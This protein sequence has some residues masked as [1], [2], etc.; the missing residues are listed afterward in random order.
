V[1]MLGDVEGNNQGL[2]DDSEKDDDSGVDDSDEIGEEAVHQWQAT[3]E[4]SL[5]EI[6][7]EALYTARR[8]GFTRRRSFSFNGFDTEVGY[9]R[10][11]VA[12]MVDLGDGEQ[13]VEGQDEVIELEEDKKN[14]ASGGESVKKDELVKAQMVVDAEVEVEVEDVEDKLDKVEAEAGTNKRRRRRVKQ[15][16]GSGSPRRSLRKTDKK[17]GNSANDKVGIVKE[18]GIAKEVIDKKVIDKKVEGGGFGK[19]AL[20]TLKF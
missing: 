5:V 19:L 18:K 12:D 11:G 4:H 1:A 7:A 2:D 15:V 20:G 13:P 3:F 10:F 16:V 8:L 6:E 17:N 14:E 9:Q